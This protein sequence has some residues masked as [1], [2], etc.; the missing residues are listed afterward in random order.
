MHLI[1]DDVATSKWFEYESRSA[2]GCDCFFPKQLLV[3][4]FI[5]WNS[6]YSLS[7][8]TPSFFIL[9]YPYTLHA[10]KGVPFEVVY[11]TVGEVFVE[12]TR[13]V[14]NGVLLE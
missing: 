8:T 11:L 5:F 13:E 14:P 7:L 2:R 3:M 4:R 6:L 10:K 12:L 1:V 9:V